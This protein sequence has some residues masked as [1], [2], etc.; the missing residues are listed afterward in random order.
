[1]LGVDHSELPGQYMCIDNAKALLNSV[2]AYS[3]NVANSIDY[4]TCEFIGP[5][6][7]IYGSLKRTFLFT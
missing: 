2:F 3:L 6:V 5:A 7:S 1:L 4:F